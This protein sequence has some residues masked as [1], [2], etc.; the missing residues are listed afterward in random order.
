MF[1]DG[2]NDAEIAEVELLEALVVLP[3]WHEKAWAQIC[4]VMM[5]W[6]DSRQTICWLALFL[7]RE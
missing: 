2:D 6:T 4:D 3:D 7:A 5:V 1:L